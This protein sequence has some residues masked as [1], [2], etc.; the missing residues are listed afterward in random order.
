MTTSPGRRRWTPELI[1]RRL[2]LHARIDEIARHDLS[3]SAR[4]RLSA[5]IITTAIDDG[6]L[7]EADALAA[8]D[9]VI[10]EA[11]A[12]VGAVAHAA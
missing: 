7:D 4:I 11:D 3:A 5:F 8:F 6:E 9:R 1:L 2:E 10:R 12:L